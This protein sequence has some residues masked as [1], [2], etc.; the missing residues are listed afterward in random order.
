MELAFACKGDLLLSHASFLAGIG[1]VLSR[2]I[3]L[4]RQATAHLRLV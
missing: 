2:F 1:E 3:D 4:T